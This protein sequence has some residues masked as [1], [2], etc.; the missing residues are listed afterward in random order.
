MKKHIL[1]LS[2]ILFVKFLLG[3]DTKLEIL[4]QE[5]LC[6]VFSY[7]KADSA[8][9]KFLNKHFPYLTGKRPTGIVFTPPISKTSKKGVLAMKFKKHP[10]FDFNIIGGQVNFK[11]IKNQGVPIFEV[12]AELHLYFADYQSADSA[13]KYI[14]ELYK[15]VTPNQDITIHDAV[16]TGEF[17]IAQSQDNDKIIFL[18][19][20][21][22][23]DIGYKIIFLN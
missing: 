21:K 20:S 4:N 14:C 18:E 1:T 9:T 12:G 15:E 17:G 7:G 23:G 13:F 2:L 8:T 5:M 16:K 22:N 10:Y 11:T 19:L 3:Q 6:N